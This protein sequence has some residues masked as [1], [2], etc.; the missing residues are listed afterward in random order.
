[1]ACP[2]APRQLVRE[3]KQIARDHGMRVAECQGREGTEYVLY[4]S[5]PHQGDV[6]IG[7]RSTPDGIRKFVAKCADFE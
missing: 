2:R 3:A 6:R 5:L 7:K 1:M 4:R